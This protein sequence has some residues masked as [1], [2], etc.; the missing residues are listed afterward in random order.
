MRARQNDLV[1]NAIIVHFR[2]ECNVKDDEEIECKR[3]QKPKLHFMDNRAAAAA[4]TFE[5][6]TEET[7]REPELKK[8]KQKQIL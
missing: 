2:I 7:K 4:F 6:L 1:K 3:W 8:K 5:K